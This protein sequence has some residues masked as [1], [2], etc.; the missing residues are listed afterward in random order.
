MIKIHGESYFGLGLMSVVAANSSCIFIWVK[1]LTLMW[2]WCTLGY[3]EV[4]RTKML[5]L[6]KLSNL[7]HSSNGSSEL[8]PQSS[9]TSH[10]QLWGM[11]RPLRHLNCPGRQVLVEQW[12]G[13]SSDWSP[14]SSSLSHCHDSGMHRLFAHCH[15]WVSHWCVA[16]G[17]TY[18]NTKS[19]ETQKWEKWHNFQ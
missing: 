4:Y 2:L 12:A 16:R 10:F 3:Q 19:E 13:S 1:C 11:Q 15:W 5:V 7:L 17:K 9:S 14:Q 18:S 8:S 6:V